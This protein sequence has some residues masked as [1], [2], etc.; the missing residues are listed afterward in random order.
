MTFRRSR[1]DRAHTYML[2]RSGGQ[3]GVAALGSERRGC[4]PAERAVRAP[5]PPATSDA[6]ALRSAVVE[7][8]AC[9]PQLE[10]P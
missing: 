6:P 7:Q 2:L 10:Q 1:K 9:P 4:A 3:A 5:C 8:C